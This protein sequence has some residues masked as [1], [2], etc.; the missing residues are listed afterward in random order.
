M[1]KFSKKITLDY[2]LDF[3][4][5]I[6]LD[7]ENYP[8][9]IPWCK[10]VKILH[11]NKTDKILSAELLVEFSYL[12]ERYISKTHYGENE[13]GVFFVKTEDINGPF[14]YLKSKWLLQKLSKD[15]QVIFTI[16]FE[17]ESKLLQIIA[18][19]V[20]TQKAEEMIELFRNYANFLKEQGHAKELR[21]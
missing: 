8:K 11:H 19:K 13:N 9:F 3:I 18:N 15:I 7:V 17:F 12:K 1:H 21:K 10:E 2:K 5:S 20:F 16:E 14:K 4:K 6:V